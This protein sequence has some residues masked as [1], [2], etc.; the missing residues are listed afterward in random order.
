MV[1]PAL[2]IGGVWAYRGY[3]AYRAYR[4][5]QM[6]QRLDRAARAASRPGEDAGSCHDCEDERDRCPNLRP[7]PRYETNPMHDPR[8]PHFSRN[9][10]PEPSNASQI[11]QNAVADPTGNG[12]QWYAVHN[13][14]VYR[15]SEAGD[16]TAHFS[17]HT[18]DPNHE[19]RPPDTRVQRKLG[20]T[21][22]WRPGRF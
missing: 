8:S 9:K 20:I 15:F 18:N 22:R 17:G 13:G 19:M 3:Q 1:A 21:G 10:T 7:R 4:V 11:F 16:G 14:H 2:V 6:A 12:R 5:Y